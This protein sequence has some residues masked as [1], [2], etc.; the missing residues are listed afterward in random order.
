MTNIQI[1]IESQEVA[2]LLEKLRRKTSHLRPVMAEIAE[3][4]R[5]SVEKNFKEESSR[6]PIGGEK[7]GVWADLSPS[8]LKNRAKQRKTGRK[9]QVTG[10]LLAS[11]QP[12]VSD[13]EAFIGTNKKQAQ[14]L[15]SGT[16]KIPARPFMVLQQADIKEFENII[17]EYLRA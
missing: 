5:N 1:E 3:T 6:N 15:H 9:L 11:I 4:M 7:K 13:S 17:E 16:D 12:K 10:Q 2:S 14:A 8:T